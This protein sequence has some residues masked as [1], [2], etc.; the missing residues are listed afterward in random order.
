LEPFSFLLDQIISRLN[1]VQ[2]VASCFYSKI[3]HFRTGP[4]GHRPHQGEEIDYISI[5]AM[6]ETQLFRRMGPRFFFIGHGAAAGIWPATW[7]FHT[8][9]RSMTANGRFG[10]HHPTT[11]GQEAF[12][13]PISNLQ[14]TEDDKRLIGQTPRLP[15]ARCCGLRARHGSTTSRSRWLRDTCEAAQADDGEPAI[16]SSGETDGVADANNKGLGPELR[17]RTAASTCGSSSRPRACAPQAI[18]GRAANL[19]K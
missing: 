7:K 4:P 18:G 17:P 5:K 15:G 10:Y 9:L 11:F 3:P 13:G 6:A 8:D 19:P 12:L 2:K 16:V 14:I 1:I